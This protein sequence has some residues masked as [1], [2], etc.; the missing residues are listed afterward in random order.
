MYQEN[1]STSKS[2]I[3]S[4]TSVEEKIVDSNSAQPTKK[5][6]QKCPH[7]GFASN[8]PSALS[9]RICKKSLTAEPSLDLVSQPSVKSTVQASNKRS[10]RSSKRFFLPFAVGAGAIL[11][12]S[13]IFL[14]S[15]LNASPEAELK[16]VRGMISFGG[17]PCAQRL[18]NEKIAKAISK[19]NP[20]VTFRYTDNDRNK[21]Q[22][23]E[24]N[25]GLIQIAFS[26]KA[27]LDSYLKE[28]KERG[29]EIKAVPYAY[30]GIAYVTH[31]GT[32]IRPLTVEELESIF[33]GRITNWK[34]LGGEDK[35]IRPVLMAGMWNNPMGI[36][37]D[38]GVNPN[39]IF[40]KDRAKGKRILK[41]TDGGIFY[42]SA[43]LAAN[44]LDEVN[45]VSI[46]KD[47][48]TVVS[49]V[50]S[51]GKTNQQA[52][53]S[54]EY[55]LVR[56]LIVMVNS[57]VFQDGNNLDPQKKGVRAFVKYLIS[58]KGQRLVEDN[59]FIPKYKVAKAKQL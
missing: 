20:D 6:K 43:T 9:C 29:V 54:G 5:A 17:E 55:P 35:E 57:E 37:L 28:A 3:S 1:H 56:A 23:Q 44:E 50:L 22:T 18:V 39:T 58:P 49:P 31:K 36:R 27:Y 30:D 41:K 8:K 15:T 10:N 13:S 14:A 7:C 25:E 11:L 46:K 2:N 33:E 45:L 12:V 21:S 26:E 40:V 32:K 47:D 38:D 53:A 4:S 42:T 52:I 51:K 24:L 16:K 48:G 19:L 34:Q 59:G